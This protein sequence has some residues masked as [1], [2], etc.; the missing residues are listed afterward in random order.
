[1]KRGL[2]IG[3]FMPVH[4]GHMALIQFAALQ[5][6][7]LIVSMTYT[8]LDPIPGP[9]RFEWLVDECRTIHN[10][11]PEISEDDFDDETLPMVERIPKWAVFLR[12]RFPKADVIFSSED[13][14]PLLA[15][16]LGVSH[17]A[18]DPDRKKFP[19]SASLIREKPFRYW[20]FIAPSAKVFFVKKICFYGPESTGKSMMA[21]HLAEKFHTEFV[22]EVSREM[23]TSN[24][25]T[26]E[27]II[28]IGH[29]QTQRVLSK[30]KEANK[31]IFCDTDLITT[32]I[33][34]RH[35]LKQVPPVL[36]ELEK[37][38]SYDQ[39]FLFDID[40][41]WIAD[42]LRDL[43]ERRAE[44][45]LVFKGELEKRKIDYTLLQGDYAHREE[46]ILKYLNSYFT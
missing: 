6:D 10:V 34:S 39:Y 20:D 9:L 23:I 29:A 12:D 28:R 37:M 14:G 44:M 25:F 17:V 36:F 30:T 11:K 33:Y 19:V 7:E 46:Q 18:F 24:D 42:G 8:P 26:L 31:L 21:R 2:V 5:C 41:P 38:I 35:Y 27:D 4:Q 16:I 1:M 22:G 15:R 43:G 13:Y 32:E 45:F 40:V 3:R